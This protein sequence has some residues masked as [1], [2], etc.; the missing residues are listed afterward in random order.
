MFSRWSAAAALAVGAF[1]GIAGAVVAPVAAFAE[2]PLLL[3]GAYVVDTA[4]VLGGDDEPR[5]TAALDSLYD[6]TGMQLYVVYVRG[7]TGAADPVVWADTTAVSNGLGAND[8]LLAVGTD[9]RQ[10]AISVDEANPLTDEQLDQL[11][12][13]VERELRYDR[14]TEAAIA[15]SESITRSIRGTIPAPGSGTD[16]VPILPIV[17]G[18]AVVGIGAFVIYRLRR[19]GHEDATTTA[20]PESM[21]QKQ[22]DTRAGSLLVQ[23]DDSLKTSEQELGFAVAQFG[24]KATKEFTEA[25]AT[26]SNNVK[27]AFTIKQRLD[28]AE[29]ES[30]TDRRSLTLRII[31]LCEQADA[32]L[33]SQADAFDALRELEKNAPAALDEVVASASATRERLASA[34][35]TLASLTS[36][37]AG[38]AVGPVAGN[39][40][41]AGKLLDFADTTVASAR[42]SI[43]AGRASDAAIA[44][45]SAQSSVGQASQLLEAIDA[46]RADLD[47]A[48]SSLDA[49]LADTAQDIAAAR[50]LPADAASA[51]L[52]PSLAAAEAALAAAQAGRTDPVTAVARLSEA[53]LALETVFTGVQQEQARIVT[54]AAQ[55]EAAVDAARAQL[56]STNEFITTRRGAIGESARTRANEADRHLQQAIALR[57]SDPI[58]ALAEAQR[59]NDLA[60]SAFALANS[61]VNRHSSAVNYGGSSWAGGSDGADLGGI[62]GGLVEGMLRSGS[63]P[64]RSSSYRSSS[65]SRSSRST[66]FGGSSRSSRSSSRSSGGRRSRGGRF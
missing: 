18:V 63:V 8:I 51:R 37:Y 48:N 13:D 41:Q 52:E 39:V 14:W 62:L 17:G 5:I 3:E 64:R 12:V 26:A 9:T 6:N 59:A 28:D 60:S 11:E 31:E 35:A 53:N 16:G 15:A 27:E 44:L 65:P 38:S 30:D 47:A 45:R 61:E 1:A 49:L 43:A 20:A 55:L 34:G 66:S 4:G 56:S 58:A 22:L 25:F 29:P 50:A 33:D 42:G 19:R 46:R 7:F 36:T 23:L 57:T 40:T 10:Y 54:A 21:T 2:D 24:D 32:E